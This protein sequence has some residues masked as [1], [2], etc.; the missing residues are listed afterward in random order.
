MFT[1][2][3]HAPV[4]VY[5]KLDLDQSWKDLV[6]ETRCVFDHVAVLKILQVTCMKPPFSGV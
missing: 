1:K 3:L 2:V 4:F 6:L 5:C